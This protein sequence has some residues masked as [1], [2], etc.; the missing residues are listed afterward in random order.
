MTAMNILSSLNQGHKKW[1]KMYLHRSPLPLDMCAL[2]DAGTR[3]NVTE[4]RDSFM[5]H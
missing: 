4:K 1:S 2:R 3:R 5:P